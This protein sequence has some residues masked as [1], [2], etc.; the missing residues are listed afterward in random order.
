MSDPG[1]TYRTRE[2]IQQMRCT[3]FHTI[4]IL[5]AVAYATMSALASN[6]PITGLKT[7]LLEWGVT[8]ESELKVFLFHNLFPVRNLFF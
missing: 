7:R 8:E 4:L 5:G 3:V 2:E 6:D 1:T